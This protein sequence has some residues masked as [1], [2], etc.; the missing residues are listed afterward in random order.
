M[1]KTNGKLE[2]NDFFCTRCGRQGI[3]IARRPGHG[4]EAGHLKKI[5]CLHCKQEVNFCEIKPF[6]TKY[7]YD[8][9]VLE[10]ENGNF[11]DNG[12][13]ILP[14]NLFKQKLDKENK[15]Y[16]LQLDIFMRNH[17]EGENNNE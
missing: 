15:L 16:Q 1:R 14:Y 2:T 12:N 6:A 9:F 5:F 13:R 8:D 10:F 4:R 7:T 11:D 3:P 17:V